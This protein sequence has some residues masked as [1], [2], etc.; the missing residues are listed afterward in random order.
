VAKGIQIAA[1]FGGYCQAES[2]AKDPDKDAFLRFRK[3]HPEARHWT[4][5]FNFRD[6]HRRDLLGRWNRSSRFLETIETSIDRA[7]I[8][9][10]SMGSHV[11]I[12]FALLC[13]KLAP[14][15]EIHIVLLAPDPKYIE[16]PL[17]RSAGN[18]YED[19]SRLWDGVPGIE[20]ELAVKSL[21][22]GQRLVLSYSR[23]DTIAVWPGNV[24]RLV[25]LGEAYLR[26]EEA[27]VPLCK[28]PRE[29]H[30]LLFKD[31]FR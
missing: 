24:E 26:A 16:T 5:H 13:R 14:K 6:E 17:D 19:A 30:E 3:K 10:W 25:E 2:E 4:Q 1:F 18:A 15:A 27:D 31:G 20:M 11:A 23:R 12:R 7:E 8:L 29:I 9:A 22:L 28:S 21:G